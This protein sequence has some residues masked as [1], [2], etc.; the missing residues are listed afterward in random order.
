MQ[1][2]KVL[3]AMSG[4][5]DSSTAAALLKAQG[6]QV[7]GVTMKLFQ[8]CGK[9][10]L[11]SC[12]GYAPVSDAKRVAEKL[13]IPHMVLDV[14]KLFASA[15]VDDFCSEYAKGRTPNP[16]V[17]CNAFLKFDFL[18]KQARLFGMEYV[19]TGHYAKISLGRL[20]KGQDEN[21]DQ[22]YFLYMLKPGTLERILF[23]VGEMTKEEVRQTAKELDLPVHDKR[24]SQDICFLPDGDYAAFMQSRGFTGVKGFM[25]HAD[26][27]PA[28]EHLGLHRY[29]I[30]QRKGLP[31][32][33]ERTYVTAIDA[34][35]NTITLGGKK[36][37]QAWGVELSGVTL[38]HDPVRAG[39][40]YEVRIRYRSP[41]VDGILETLDGERMRIRFKTPVES[42]APGQS[43]VLYRGNE[44]MGG[45]IIERKLEKD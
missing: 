15:V 1:K 29:T 9:E 13:G 36:E 11:K 43:A 26:G 10:S 40:T 22:S 27:S 32:F 30:G 42:V 25:F 17:R 44:V 20:F 16:C 8:S 35:A 28:G 2:L 34:T 41:A 45:G 4:G 38:C 6:H 14:R 21:K 31:P 37:L 24:E 7:T 5:V 23:P 12:C 39:E 19:A 33:G 18:L 3:V